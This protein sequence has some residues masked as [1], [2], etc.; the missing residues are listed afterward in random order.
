[1]LQ[2]ACLGYL[3]VLF[4]AITTHSSSEVAVCVQQ[5]DYLEYRMQPIVRPPAGFSNAAAMLREGSL[6]PLSVDAT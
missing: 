6:W 3:L 1:M 5:H 2:G 4:G